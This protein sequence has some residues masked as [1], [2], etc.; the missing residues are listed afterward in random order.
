MIKSVSFLVLLGAAIAW[1]HHETVNSLQQERI[2]TLYDTIVTKADYNANLRPYGVN[3]TDATYVYIQVRD[4]NIIHVD[5][6]LGV[7]T[8]Q[9]YFRKEWVD[10]RLAYNDTAVSYIPVKDCKSLWTPDLFFYNG[11][12]VSKFPVNVHLVP[13]SGRIYPNGRV[14]KRVRVTQSIHCPALL[15]SGVKDVVCPV[16]VGSFGHFTDQLMVFYKDGVSTGVTTVNP[17]DVILPNFNFGGVT[18]L[19]KCEGLDK[20]RPSEVEGHIHSCVQAD[21]KFTRV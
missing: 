13:K 1:A 21:F 4:V 11:I 19:E 14:S 9:A 12:D 3:G 16:R 20:V 6:S 5:T 10:P 8:F 2:K 17:K 7:F 18:V 15:K